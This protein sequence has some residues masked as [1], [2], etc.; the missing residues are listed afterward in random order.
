M[1]AFVEIVNTY[2]FKYENDGKRPV[3]TGKRWQGDITKFFTVW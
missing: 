3:V 2:I 1:V